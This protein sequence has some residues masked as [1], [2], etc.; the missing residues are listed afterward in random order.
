MKQ[1]RRIHL[2][3]DEDVSGISGTGI[4]AYGAEFPDGTV[5]LRWDT[6]VVST[7]VYAS[8]DDLVA[9]SGHGGKTRVVYDDR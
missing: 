5:V 7:Q 1:V 4:V 9:I 8:V 3:R 2:E 6:K